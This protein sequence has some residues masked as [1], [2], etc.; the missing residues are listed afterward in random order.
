MKRASILLIT[1]CLLVAGCATVKFSEQNT[2]IVMAKDIEKQRPKN[3]SD[4]FNYHGDIYVFNTFRWDDA[5]KPAL[6]HTVKTKWFNDDK[7]ISTRQYYSFFIFTPYY[8]WLRTGG[9]TLGVGKCRV[10]VYVDDIYVG[11]K[12]FTVVEK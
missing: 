6:A 11:S 5:E 9:T 8:V 1:I 2:T 7:L 3:I 4:T 12:S 10:E